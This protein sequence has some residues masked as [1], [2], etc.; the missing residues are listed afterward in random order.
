[1]FQEQ[2]LS[3]LLHLYIEYGRLNEAFDLAIDC[4]EILIVKLTSKHSEYQ[5]VY[6]PMNNIDLLLH[7]SKKHIQSHQELGEKSNK[8]NKLLETYVS[9]CLTE[10][11]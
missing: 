6:F 11:K 5:N 4:I 1:M 3:E 10:V 8:L 2:N 7:I 9:S